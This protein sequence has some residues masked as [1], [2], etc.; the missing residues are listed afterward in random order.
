MSLDNRMLIRYQIAELGLSFHC[1]RT[2]RGKIELLPSGPSWK[3]TTVSMSG[4][5]TKDP[6]VLYYRDPIEC[7]EFLLKNPLFSGH[8]QYQ[9][10][11]DFNTSGGRMYGEWITSDGAWDL[12]VCFLTSYFIHS[13]HPEVFQV[14]TS[15]PCHSSWCNTFIRQNKTQC[16]DWRSR[17]PPPAH[18]ACKR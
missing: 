9:P 11:Q 15:I 17:R 12:Q 7:I 4:Y 1:A 8:I 14:S 2:L 13:I 6:L 16:N 3:S 5:S 18:H 10:R